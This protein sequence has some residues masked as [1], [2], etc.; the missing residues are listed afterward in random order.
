M[1][2][3]LSPT[4]YLVKLLKFIHQRDNSARKVL[5]CVYLITALIKVFVP[6]FKVAV[7]ALAESV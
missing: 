5:E 4:N 6:A 1:R 2:S 3:F 7:V